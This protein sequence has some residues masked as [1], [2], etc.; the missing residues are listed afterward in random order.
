M[1][2]ITALFEE[3]HAQVFVRRSQEPIR[4][5]H[6]RRAHRAERHHF[7][8]GDVLHDRNARGCFFVIAKSVVND[9]AAASIQAA[10]GQDL[11]GAPGAI[12]APS[13]TWR[14]RFP[15][16]AAGY[17]FG[18]VTAGLLFGLAFPGWPQPTIP[19]A[20][21]S[22]S[23]TIPTAFVRV[24]Q[25][26]FAV[27]ALRLQMAIA[28]SRP[29]RREYN[30][31]VAIAP[32]DA[33]PQP[34]AALLSV[35]AIQGVPN[36]AELRERFLELVPELPKRLLGSNSFIDHLVQRAQSLGASI[37]VTKD[38]AESR[39][40]IFITTIESQI[41][42]G[43]LRAALSDAEN[44]DPTIRPYLTAWLSDLQARVAV[45]EA[46]AELVAVAIEGKK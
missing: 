34:I 22:S 24:E 15:T 4:G 2:N 1:A 14:S 6:R 35:H 18:L 31:L 20:A 17:G 19:V 33:I 5:A 44:L 29:W 27:A 26:S 30:A 41:R 43:N 10:G 42:R 28:S 39:G 23:G 40:T 25:N 32:P 3:P 21:Q 11:S 7:F 38:G 8:R 16:L 45:E 13:K 36:E 12:V 9:E 46:V 37:G